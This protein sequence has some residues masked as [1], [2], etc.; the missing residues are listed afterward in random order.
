VC[1]AKGLVPG[2]GGKGIIFPKAPKD[3]E[4]EGSP[5]LGQCSGY[6]QVDCVGEDGYATDSIFF[7]EV[8]LFSAICSNR[9]DLFRLRS[10]DE[11]ECDLDEGAYWDL[12][13]KLRTPP[14]GAW[15]LLARSRHRQGGVLVLVELPKKERRCRSALQEGTAPLGAFIIFF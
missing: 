7:L 11:W 3:L 15:Q 13:E 14:V 2:Q 5:R 9:Q 10:G 6:S 4:F 8:C 12:I 1:A